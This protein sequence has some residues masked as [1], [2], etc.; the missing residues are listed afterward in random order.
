MIPAILPMIPA[1]ANDPGCHKIGSIRYGFFILFRQLNNMM[2]KCIKVY[3]PTLDNIK[4]LVMP[5]V[6]LCTI[7]GIQCLN[8]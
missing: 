8:L 4:V 3:I 6:V 1:L 5:S 2:D 7:F